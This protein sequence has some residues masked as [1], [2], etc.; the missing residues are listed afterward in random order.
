MP[1]PEI[2]YLEWA[3]ARYGA[4]R[5]DLANSGIPSLPAAELGP[6]PDAAR[7]D[8]DEEFRALAAARLSVPPDEIVPAHGASGAI[9]L[10]CAALLS[11]GDEALCEQPFYEPMARVPEA[12]GARVCFFERRFE[13]GFRLDPERVA[14]ALTPRTRLVLV[15]DAHNPSGVLA[16]A[17]DLLAVARLAEDAGAHLV[18]NEI[19]RDFHTDAG[20]ARAHGEHVV[21]LRSLT[22]VYGIGWARAG[23]LCGPP[24][25]A[26]QARRVA[27]ATVGQVGGACLA[28]GIAAL[29]HLPRLAARSRALLGNKR[30]RVGAFVA[31]SE[32]LEWV[33]P[34]AGL[35]A[36]PRLRPPAR[37][38]ALRALAERLFAEDGLLFT[39]GEFFGAPAHLRLT[40][41]LPD[42]DL[43]RALAILADALNRGAESL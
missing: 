37:P 2:R 16:R 27:Q 39:P 43:E 26:R 42:A 40:W 20:S 33:D 35:H 1:F 12:L 11:P 7:G 28:P 23:W 22:K 6:L 5:L 41:G 24:A 8:L 30:A 19:Y 14:A 15:T 3:L 31:G 17:E 18:V 21:V 9:F 25:V 10:S 36:F 4:L 34:G 32:Q 38:G 29:R 13:D